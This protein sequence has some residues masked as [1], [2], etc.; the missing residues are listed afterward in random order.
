[1]SKL[2]DVLASRELEKLG[3][4][5]LKEL[6]ASIKLH[7]KQCWRIKIQRHRNSKNVMKGARGHIQ[8]GKVYIKILHNIINWTRTNA[9]EEIFIWW[10]DIKI[11]HGFIKGNM[12]SSLDS[13]SFHVKV[14]NILHSLGEAKE[15]TNTGIRESNIGALGA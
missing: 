3:D 1:M 12:L 4:I 15:D 9:V 6:V 11:I 13:L 10:L 5:G 2:S 7:C 8:I 14:Q